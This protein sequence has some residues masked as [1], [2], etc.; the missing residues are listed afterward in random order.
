M[1]NPPSY[2]LLIEQVAKMTFPR[3][4]AL[5]V[6]LMDG[7]IVEVSIQYKKL[8][9]MPYPTFHSETN[10]DGNVEWIVNGTICA[11]HCP[12]KQIQCIKNIRSEVLGLLIWDPSP[13]EAPVCHVYGCRNI[14]DESARERSIMIR[15]EIIEAK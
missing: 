5:R 3:W 7:G 15:R 13:Y 2:K 1:Q 11:V 9:D 4:N 6:W 8:S 14:V 12:E 10:A